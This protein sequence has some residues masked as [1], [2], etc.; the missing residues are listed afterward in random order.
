MFSTAMPSAYVLQGPRSS[1]AWTNDV[2]GHAA[3]S[4][5]RNFGISC[6]PAAIVDIL[7]DPKTVI[8]QADVVV[9]GPRLRHGERTPASGIPRAR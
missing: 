2:N 7:H 6:H 3:N 9:G 8:P 1:S 5:T 4:Y